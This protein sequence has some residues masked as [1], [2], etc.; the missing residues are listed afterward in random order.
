[1]SSQKQKDWRVRRRGGAGGAG[2]SM[3]LWQQQQAL[4]TH[5][6]PVLDLLM[7][8]WGSRPRARPGFYLP[9]VQQLI[10]MVLMRS[11][12]SWVKEEGFGWGAAGI[13]RCGLSRASLHGG[14]VLGF[15]NPALTTTNAHALHVL[16]STQQMLLA[17]T[18]I[19]LP[20]WFTEAFS[21][22]A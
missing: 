15:P 2:V 17:K 22:L 19:C 8:G 20:Q 7:W 9:Q 14:P 4:L 16:I 1:M 3:P 21:T 5:T 11:R 12:C 6:V 18:E 10:I 13:A